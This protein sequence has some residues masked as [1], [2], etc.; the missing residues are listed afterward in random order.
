MSEFVFFANPLLACFL[1]C[2][3]ID[4]IYLKFRQEA[5]DPAIIIIIKN[6]QDFFEDEVTLT[7]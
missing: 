7:G 2:N 1:C 6:N 5:I 4:D 3:F